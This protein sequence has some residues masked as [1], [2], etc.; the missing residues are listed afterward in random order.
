[1]FSFFQNI[2]FFAGSTWITIFRFIRI[3][4]IVL[5]IALVFL[6]I[7]V[8]KKALLYY[9]PFVS[10]KK[11]PAL[12]G[13]ALEEIPE[14]PLL[15]EEWENLEAK[16]S[17]CPDDGWAILVIEADKL[18]DEGMK[19]LGIPGLTMLE[20]LQSLA[21]SRENM[22]TLESFWKA[23]KVRNQ[24][25]HTHGYILSPSEAKT[26]LDSYKGFLEELGLL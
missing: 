12:K 25:A 17:V 7:Y 15:N 21:R 26:Y 16:A 1:M 10:H 14:V 3:I 24:I 5:D 6:I 9:P 11:I 2:D 20:R 4:F 23:H 8:L 13:G 22:K 18:A 19:R